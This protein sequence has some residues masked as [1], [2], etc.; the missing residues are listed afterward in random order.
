MAAKDTLDRLSSEI[1]ND[2][3]KFKRISDAII[4]NRYDVTVD[5]LI[6][7]NGL[8]SNNLS[9]GQILKIPVNVIIS[10][11]DYETYIVKSG[12]T[13]YSIGKRF[14]TKLSNKATILGGLIL[15]FIGVE[16][17]LKGIL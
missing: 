7:L 14:G 9:V 15:I 13:L 8:N 2:L 11:T 1:I 10:D 6:K 5:E 3:E 4:A 17:F 12:D 16:I